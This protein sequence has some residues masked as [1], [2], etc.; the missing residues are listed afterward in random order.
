MQSASRVVTDMSPQNM[1]SWFS[2]DLFPHL[3]GSP[4]APLVNS[5]RNIKSTAEVSLMREIGRSS[6]RV[7]TEAMRQFWQSESELTAFL[8]Y[9]FRVSGLGGSA[10]IPVVAGGTNA[11]TIHYT[12]NNA[13]ISP[14]DLVLVDAGGEKGNYITDI[15]RTFPSQRKFGPAQRDLYNAL[16]ATQRHC[17]TFCRA[18]SGKSLD[19]IHAIAETHLED[20]LTQLGFS[21]KKSSLLHHDRSI[22]RLF[23][24][25]IGHYI[26]LDVHDTPGQSRKSPLQRGQ[27]VT[28]EPGIYVPDSDEFPAAFR[29]MGIRIEDSIAIEESG[30]IV[31][32][33]EAVKEI[34]DIEALS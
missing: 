13:L 11:S 2:A 24:H 4:L 28:I 25:H 8:D 3:G 10:Y 7:F 21:L 30:P 27:C 29:G 17:I 22:E 32:T 1:P 12:A 14:R 16:L 15:T 23:P 6:G 9:R 26:G 18:S 31:L 5:L 19:D 20:Q 33:T 34:D